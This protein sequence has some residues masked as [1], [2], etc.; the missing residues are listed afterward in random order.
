MH[1]HSIR[2]SDA[3][4]PGPHPSK[5]S[6]EEALVAFMGNVVKARGTHGVRCVL[7]SAVADFKKE[8]DQGGVGS[9]Q[10]VGNELEALHLIENS[11][12]SL[13]CYHDI[14]TEE[15]K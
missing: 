13:K 4:R 2:K 7:I 14:A 6:A 15:Q 11:V 10:I 12:L 1:I 9:V 8:D 5:E 3:E